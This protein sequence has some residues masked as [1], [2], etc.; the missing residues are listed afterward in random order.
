MGGMANSILSCKYQITE[1]SC[2]GISCSMLS[3]I[4]II[5]VITLFV[6]NDAIQEN[7]PPFG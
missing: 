5:Q 4:F 7:S 6:S 1:V 2:L 3:L